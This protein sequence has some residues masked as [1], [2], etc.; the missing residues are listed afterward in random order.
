[1]I[2]RDMKGVSLI[3]LIIGVAIVSILLAAALPNFRTMMLGIQIKTAAEAL[4]NGIQLAKAEAVR[5]NTNVIFTLGAGTAWTVG[6]VTPIA[7]ADGDGVDECPATIQSR[8]N[9][10]GS[11]AVTVTVSP[12]GA[13]TVTFNG[14]GRAVTGTS[15]TRLDVGVSGLGKALRILISGGSV[16]MC[17]PTIT[18]TSNARR[19]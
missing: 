19:C 10:F 5:R 12:V 15:I 14:F 8:A 2:L 13:T 9:E 11:D 1:L 16:R 3:E 17:D 18:S 4:N 6:C 7:D